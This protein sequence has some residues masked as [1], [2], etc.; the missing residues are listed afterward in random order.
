MSSVKDK[1]IIMD[2]NIKTLN[3][4]FEKPNTLKID[5]QRGNF[6]KALQLLLRSKES[7]NTRVQYYSEWRKPDL[8]R[9]QRKV[10]NI[11]LHLL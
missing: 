9:G 11:N 8:G 4:T 6:K 5:W 1:H 3:M 2:L 10:L 7:I